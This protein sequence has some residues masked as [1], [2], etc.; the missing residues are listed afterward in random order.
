[1]IRRSALLALVLVCEQAH[2]REYVPPATIICA[3][4][5]EAEGESYTSKLAHAFLFV[6][7]VHAGMKLGSSGLDSR[8]VRARLARASVDNWTEARMAVSCALSG[9]VL[10]PTHGALYCENVRAFG[11]PG[12]IKRALRA[13]RVEECAKVGDVTFW[14]DK[15]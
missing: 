14:G 1:M 12:Y 8:K 7:R 5:N 2:A 4:M 9:S 3:V 6:N 11:V 10:D 15:R 13:G